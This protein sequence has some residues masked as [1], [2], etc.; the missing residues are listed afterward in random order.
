MRNQLDKIAKV[1]KLIGNR[2]II[3][4][5]DGGINP[6]TAAEASAAGADMLVAGTAVF[7]GGNFAKNINAL[8]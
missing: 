3:L 5:V 4:S 2:N 1:R 7:A 6:K 8:R